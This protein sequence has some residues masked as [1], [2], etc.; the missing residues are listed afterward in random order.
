MIAEREDTGPGRV[1]LILAVAGQ[2]EPVPAPAL[3]IVRTDK[4]PIYYL[5]EGIGRIIA[6]KGFDFLSRRRQAN[7]VKCDAAEQSALVSRTHRM[8]AVPFQLGQN[9]MVHR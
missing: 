3:T 5:G 9:E 4:K 1:R 7:Q 6:Y 2:V 8:Q